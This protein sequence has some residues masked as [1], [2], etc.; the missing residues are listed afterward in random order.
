MKFLHR[1]GE[2]VIFLGRVFRKP[3]KWKLFRANILNEMVVLGISSMPIITIISF[4]MGAVIT[5]QTAANTGGG[6]IPLYTIGF[7][8]RE[9]VILEFSPTIVALILV[10]KIGS[11]ISSE[12]GTMRVTEQIDAI[13][14]MG[15]NSASFLV[16]PKIIALVILNPF[17]ITLSIFLAIGGGFVAG[18]GTG[19]ITPYDYEYGILYDFIPFHFTYSMIKSVFFGFIITSVPAFFGY[20]VKGGSVEVARSS[21]QSVVQ[22]SIVILIINYLLTQLLLL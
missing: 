21:T 8:V 13:E 7:A 1:F 11:S 4:F 10:G 12:L 19:A 9:S 6:L 17:L 18:V 3:E 16:Q 14:I 15:I 22:S 5:I 20:N 2:Y